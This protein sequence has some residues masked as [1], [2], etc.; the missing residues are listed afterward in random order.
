MSIPKK[1]SPFIWHFVKRQPVS[2]FIASFTA[3]IWAVNEV[4]FPYFIKSFVNTISTFKGDPHSIYSAILIPLTGLIVSWVVMDISM[5]TQGIVLISAFPK[6]RAQIRESVFNYIKHHS[7]QYFSNNF[8]GTLA[9]KMSSLPTSCQVI[10]EIFMYTLGSMS[11]GIIFSCVLM[12]LA[13]PFFA[14][15]LIVWF[16]FHMGLTILFIKAGDK[17]WELHS[18]SVTSLSG[19]IVDSITNMTSVRLF[20]RSHFESEYLKQAQQ[21]EINKAKQASWLMEL[22]RIAQGIAGLCFIFSMIFTLIHGWIN[23]WVT[24]GDFSLISMLS[25]WVLGSVWYLSYQINVL[26]REVSTVKEA[27]TLITVKHEVVD[28]PNAQP[29]TVKLG[30]ICFQD[31]TFAYNKDHP[32][33]QNLTINIP[34]GQKIGLVGFSGSGKSTFVNLILRFYDIQKGQITID[35]QNIEQ[36]T[37]ESLRGQIAL[38]PQDP[39]L[40]HRTLMENIRYGRIEASD[41]EVIEASKLAHCHEFIERLPDGYASLVGERG[42]KLSGGQRQRIAIARA[43]LKDAPILILDEATS[44]LDSV[45]EKL[46]QESLLYLMKNRTTIIIA[47]RL[48]TLADMDKILVFHKGEIVEEGTQ[49]QLLAMQNGHFSK[50]WEMQAHG[51]IVDDEEDRELP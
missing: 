50:L 36:V 51:F 8:A 10:V 44:S 25:F 38:I 3:L 9:Q 12:W 26:V 24:L 33:F 11:V 19:K 46:I 31:V 15:I 29:L 1:I 42:I 28:A 47:H 16:C 40:F 37:Q 18:E 43:I 23:G 34:A 27:L 17:R 39:S 41:A 21:E 13:S 49:E 4:L 6:F 5:R 30:N 20:A 2:F 35:E 14:S 22:M 32:V 48:S 45:T 7:H